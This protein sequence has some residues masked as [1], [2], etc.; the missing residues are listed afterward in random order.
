MKPVLPYTNGYKAG[1]SSYSISSAE[2]N[3][4]EGNDVIRGP[5]VFGRSVGAEL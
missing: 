1:L 3:D 4:I 2:Q 5:A